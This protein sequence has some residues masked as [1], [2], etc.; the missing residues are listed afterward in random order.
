MDTPSGCRSGRTSSS[1][2]RW[3][4]NTCRRRPQRTLLRRM[5]RAQLELVA[6][7]RRQ[8]A[9]RPRRGA[10][11]A[12]VVVVADLPAD[13]GSQRHHHHPGPADT[14]SCRC[15]RRRPRCS[16]PSAPGA[17][18]RRSTRTRTTRRT[19]PCTK[20]NA[21]TPNVEAIVAYKPDL[22]IV[23]GDTTGL[24][25]QLA[26]LRHPGAVRSAGG[27]PRTRNTQQFD[28][29]GQATG[30]V[31]AGRDR[32]GQDQGA[33]SR[34]SCS[35]APKHTQADDVLLRARPDLLLGDVVDLHRP[36]ARPAGSAAASPTRPRAAAS[37]GGYPQLS[38][39][40]IIKSNPDYIFL[41]DTLCCGQTPR[42]WRQ[43]A[44]LVG[45][46]PPCKDGQV[47]GAERRHRVTVGSA[48]RDLL[49][50]VAN[51]RQAAPGAIVSTT[52]PDRP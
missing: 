25:A 11:T 21:L 47:V 41:A 26:K 38:A 45:P 35:D 51:A 30:H 48:H 5:R 16:M 19:R 40:F 12:A 17:R 27:Q 49:Q 18:S 36:G 15:R 28:E 23:A 32:G 14:R 37:S 20:L 2:T 13:H 8:R 22:V 50:T 39:E 1:A 46:S 52:V 4:M 7:P 6:G 44:R 24:T 34:R 29:L 33:R 31:R 43:A 10:A 9:G 42:R 3:R